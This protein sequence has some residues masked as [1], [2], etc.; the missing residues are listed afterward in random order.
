MPATET[1][2]SITPAASIC[3]FAVAGM[4]RSYR[5]PIT[6]GTPHR[7]CAGYVETAAGTVAGPSRI[8]LRFI[9]AT[10]AND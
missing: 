2:Q 1:S 5:Q 4:A 6:A 3:D 8:P 10:L 7:L 9:Q